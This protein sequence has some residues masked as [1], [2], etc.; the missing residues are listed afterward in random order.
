MRTAR[1]AGMRAAGMRAVGVLWGFRDREELLESG[2]EVPIE[3]PVD[4]LRLL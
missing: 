3:K 2:A 1:A 4:V